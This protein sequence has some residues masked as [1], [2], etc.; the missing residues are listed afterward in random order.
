MESL[1]VMIISGCVIVEQGAILALH[2]ISPDWYEIPGGKQEPGETPDATALREAREEL[3][4][5]ITLTHYLGGAHF[6]YDRKE[7]TS[8]WYA[9]LLEDGQTPRIMEPHKFS[10][11]VRIPLDRWSDYPLSPNL[12]RYLQD[13]SMG[14]ITLHAV[15]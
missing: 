6:F 5:N 1:T 4:C 14:R 11:I 3:G 9:A 8:H 10:E 7:I 13:Y 2:R 12:Q 15:R